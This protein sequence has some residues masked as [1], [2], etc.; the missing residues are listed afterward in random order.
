MLLAGTG[1]DVGGMMRK[2]VVLVLQAWQC[3]MG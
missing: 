2:V 3:L 1:T